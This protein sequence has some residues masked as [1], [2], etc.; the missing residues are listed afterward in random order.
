MQKRVT[1]NEFFEVV[2]PVKAR[3]VQP[4][5]SGDMIA[6]RLRNILARAWPLKGSSTSPCKGPLGVRSVEIYTK[7]L[8][9][10][11]FIVF[12]PS[13]EPAACRSSCQSWC[14]A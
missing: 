14:F 11:V 6:F 12:G 13:A 3:P 4:Y 5:M 9:I 8:R 7:P 1:Q 2:S 10:S